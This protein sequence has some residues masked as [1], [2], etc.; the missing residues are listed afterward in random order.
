[1]ETEKPEILTQPKDVRDIH[2]YS[3]LV[4][5]TGK[6][7]EYDYPSYRHELLGLPTIPFLG[8]YAGASYEFGRTVSLVGADMSFKKNGDAYKWI[9]NNNKQNK[10][11]IPDEVGEL[12]LNIPA[13]IEEN[14]K[15]ESENNSGKGERNGRGNKNQRNNNENNKKDQSK[16]TNF[17]SVKGDEENDKEQ[18]RSQDKNKHDD[19]FHLDDNSKPKKLLQP[20]KQASFIATDRVRF[21]WIIQLNDI[22]VSQQLQ[23]EPMLIVNYVM[24][25]VLFPFISFE[26]V[27]RI[28]AKT[29]V[30]LVIPK[31]F[32]S[33]NGVVEFVDSN[34]NQGKFYSGMKIGNL[35]LEYSSVHM[36]GQSLA[37]SPN[38]MKLVINKKV[39]I[40]LFWTVA[41]DETMQCNTCY[42]HWI[43]NETILFDMFEKICRDAKNLD[44]LFRGLEE[45][46]GKND[47]VLAYTKNVYETF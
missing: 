22:Q 26:K 34:K 15:E 25:T 14:K 31:E 24:H 13:Y 19:I 5:L 36:K 21:S 42:L 46:L 8:K 37:F 30:G 38:N 16:L 45:L 10:I 44:E 23:K 28:T 43:V 40:G 35:R 2:D 20:P 29:P 11:N 6:S 4:E 27:K 18:E 33:Q 41:L 39:P 7:S 32:Q 1:M 12:L 17:F 9:L 47:Q 3:F